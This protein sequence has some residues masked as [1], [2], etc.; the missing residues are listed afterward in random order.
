MASNTHM[1]PSLTVINHKSVSLMVAEIW[2]MEVFQNHLDLLSQ[3]HQ[4][5]GKL[6]TMT[7]SITVFNYKPVSLIG[8]EIWKIE[9]FQGQFGQFDHDLISQGHLK[10]EK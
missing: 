7:P 1:T 10:C 8:T 3:G 6:S 2:Q 4:K 5:Y 9:K